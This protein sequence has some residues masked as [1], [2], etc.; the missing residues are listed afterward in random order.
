MLIDTLRQ[1]LTTAMKAKDKLTVRTLRSVIAAVKEAEVAGDHSKVLTD[2]EIN[3]VISKQAKQRTEAADAFEQ[4]NR[5][6]QAAAERAELEVLR[7]YLPSPLTPQELDA[8]VDETLASGGWTTKAD[9]G[10]AIRAANEATKG[11]AEG[12]AVA[13]A[14]K[15]RLA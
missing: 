12:S 2:D 15:S 5:P 3:Q 4:G 10:A 6:E 7:R 11:R 14:V 1:D 8:L 13:Q 9:M